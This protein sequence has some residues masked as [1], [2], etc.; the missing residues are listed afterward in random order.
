M[1]L[2]SSRGKGEKVKKII[3]AALAGLALLAGCKSA[4]TKNEPIAPKWKGAPY[5][6][7]F[8]AKPAQP[9]DLLPG[10]KF[11]ANPEDLETRATLVIRFDSSQVK[12]TGQVMDQIVM[13]PT[14]ISGAEGALP[15]DY[16]KSANE[17]LSGLF[18]SYK[19]KGKVPVKVALARSSLNR[20]ASDAE[21]ASKRL[22]DWLPIDVEVKGAH[23]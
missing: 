8:D 13:Q 2:A 14:N 6:I 18:A 20:G 23:K 19:I 7:A 11:T 22:S 12:S 9:G 1:V 15:A 3:V 4:E 5:R 10:I 16:M 21:I 17:G